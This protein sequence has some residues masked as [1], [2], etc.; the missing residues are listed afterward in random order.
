MKER[1]VGIDVLPRHHLLHILA[2]VYMSIQG[3][4]IQVLHTQIDESN[5]LEVPLFELY[6]PHIVHS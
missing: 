4:V 5:P 3:I 2:S 1:Y 6:T